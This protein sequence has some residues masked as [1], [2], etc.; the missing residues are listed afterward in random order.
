MQQITA[1]SSKALI[2]IVF[3]LLTYAAK[4]RFAM[5]QA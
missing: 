4:K 2:A 1:V 5:N 3:Q